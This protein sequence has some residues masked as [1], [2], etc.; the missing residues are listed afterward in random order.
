MSIRNDLA[1]DSPRAREDAVAAQDVTATGAPAVTVRSMTSTPT[2]SRSTADD[3]RRDAS[4]RRPTAV[5]ERLDGYLAAVARELDARGVLTGTPQRTDPAHR[6]TGSIVLD[7]TTL[8]IA[9]WRPSQ[10][11]PVARQALANAIHPQRPTPA[12]ATWDEHD[13]W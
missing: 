5:G 4:T 12:I 9:A 7:C 11:G 8:R 1:P 2:A 6:L 3:P 13:G 10:Q